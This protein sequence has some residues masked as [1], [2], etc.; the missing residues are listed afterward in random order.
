MQ[1][2]GYCSVRSWRSYRESG[3]LNGQSSVQLR[4]SALVSSGHASVAGHTLRAEFADVL[5]FLPL[6]LVDQ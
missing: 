6:F 3:L 2:L 4:T 5:I 1:A